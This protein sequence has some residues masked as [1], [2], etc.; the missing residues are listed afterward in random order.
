MATGEV[1]EDV[2]RTLAEDDERRAKLLAVSD[3]WPAVR[4]VCS[5]RSPGHHLR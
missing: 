2:A 3:R 1:V 4:D 5:A